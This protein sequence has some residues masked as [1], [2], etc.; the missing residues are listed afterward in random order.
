M[1]YKKAI[2]SMANCNRDELMSIS[3]GFRKRKSHEIY[4][5]LRQ[6]LIDR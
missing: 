2:D 4:E 5:K 1:L 6:N 3:Q